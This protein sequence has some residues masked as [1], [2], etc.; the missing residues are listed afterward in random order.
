MELLEKK[1]IRINCQPKSKNEVI[2]SVGQ[3]LFESGYVK[4]DYI[5]A[6]VERE[7]TFSTNIGNGIALP[8]GTE[9]AKREIISS[10]IAVQVFPEGTEWGEEKVQVVIGIAGVG[11]AHLDILAHIAE[12][13]SDP[14]EVGCLVKSDE[15]GVYRMLTGKE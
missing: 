14:S 15:E 12:K 2:Q 7:K 4:K 9:N 13:L 1:N 11:D 3:M 8:H 5:A 6:M 10:G